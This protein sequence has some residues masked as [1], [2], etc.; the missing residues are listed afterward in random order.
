M[1]M[2]QSLL[3]QAAR[4]RRERSSSLCQYDMDKFPRGCCVIIN[5]ENF[6]KDRQRTGAEKDAKALEGLFNDLGFTVIVRENLSLPAVRKLLRI[7]TKTDHTNS[8]CL[9]WIMMSHGSED[10]IECSDGDNL[11][12][13][14]LYENFS[15][16]NCPTLN[17][18]PKIFI[19][20]CCRGDRLDKLIE[21]PLEYPN[22]VDTTS[23]KQASSTNKHGMHM[24][25]DK[26]DM[27]TVH[28]TFAGYAAI[29]IES[30]GSLFIQTF[31]KV[32]RDK[33]YEKEEFKQQLTVV[34][35]RMAQAR[36]P[37]SDS[38]E[39]NPEMIGHV[40]S[41]DESL[42]KNLHFYQNPWQNDR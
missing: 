25:P 24:S 3:D 14:E 16:R 40:A 32:L 21:H 38:P 41:S 18:K 7:M 37:Y 2:C 28:A 1:A 33:R 6:P 27:I 35:K 9:V 15:T 23:Y 20:Q 12:E 13:K 5:N 4:E 42:T 29:R 19:F 31:V 11:D 17:G 39:E 34:K 10:G 26:A 36:Y 30:E 8:S 22:E